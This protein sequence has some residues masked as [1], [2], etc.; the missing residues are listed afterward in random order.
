MK[1]FLKIVLAGVI[2]SAFVTTV[3]SADAAKGQKLYKK[4]LKD[5]CGFNGAEFA[6]K[7]TVDEWKAIGVAGMAK[8]IKT[9]CP[10]APDNALKEKFLQHYLDFSINFASDSGN[11]PSC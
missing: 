2:A 10:S 3:A 6:K 11:V 8:E 4:K 1:N 5:A 9:L 7:H